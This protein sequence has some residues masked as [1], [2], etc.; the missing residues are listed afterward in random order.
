MYRHLQAGVY[1]AP[2]CAGMAVL[3]MQ[4][5]QYFLLNEEQSGALMRLLGGIAPVDDIVDK[6]SHA[7]SADDAAMLAR[8]TSAFEKQGLLRPDTY[9]TP[10]SKA[11]AAAARKVAPL[12][13]FT[14]WRLN[15][16]DVGT[17]H[18]FWL[19]ARA[20]LAVRRSHR[21]TARTRM[22]GL[23][24][25]LY[26]TSRPSRSL[27]ERHKGTD[28]I[29]VAR[30]TTGD[31]AFLDVDVDTAGAPRNVTA[32]DRDT[33]G[34]SVA[35]HT[36]CA[37]RAVV[38]ETIGALNR[39]CL[40][41]PK[42]TKCLEWSAALVY[43]CQ[44]RGIDVDLVIG[45]SGGPFSAHAWVEFEG[46][47]VGDDLDRRRQFAVIVDGRQWRHPR[48]DVGVLQRDASREGARQRAGSPSAVTPA[49]V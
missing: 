37:A 39:A 8:W 47:V 34:A 46:V 25:W 29:D 42:R 17:G 44:R 40:F 18:S 15:P 30:S 31:P 10:D 23:L 2:L 41:Y 45:V 36:R 19:I 9:A 14:G 43:L 32:A 35:F 11:V 22:P 3:T 28:A 1:I 27:S 4:D 38:A 5:D 26:Q 6:T 13:G 20:W 7:D 49:S 24:Q 48:R 21:I 12:A 16:E 33:H